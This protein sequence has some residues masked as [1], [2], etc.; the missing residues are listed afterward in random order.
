MKL[1]LGLSAE[2]KKNGEYHIAQRGD[3]LTK[4]PIHWT[5][6]FLTVWEVYFSLD[7]YTEHVL[8][9]IWH[10]GVDTYTNI[11]YQ[12][13]VTL[14]ISSRVCHTKFDLFYLQYHYPFAH[15]RDEWL[16]GAIDPYVC[17]DRNRW[18]KGIPFCSVLIDAP[19]HKNTILSDRKNT[20]FI[21]IP[22][23]VHLCSRHEIS[24]RYKP[25]RTTLHRLFTDMWEA[26]FSNVFL[27][28]CTLTPQC[29]WSIYDAYERNFEI[30][31]CRLD[32]ATSHTDIHTPK[33]MSLSMSLHAPKTGFIK[34]SF[35]SEANKSPRFA[36]DADDDE[37]SGAVLYGVYPFQW[38]HFNATPQSM[39][40][41]LDNHWSA[42]VA[43]WWRD[44]QTVGI[45]C[46]NL[47]FAR[48]KLQLVLLEHPVECTDRR[49]FNYYRYDLKTDL[50]RQVPSTVPNL[51]LIRCG[52]TW[53]DHSIRMKMHCVYGV[54]TA[55]KPTN[56]ASAAVHQ[57]VAS[58]SVHRD[59]HARSPI[60]Y[61]ISRACSHIF[62]RFR[63]LDRVTLSADR[64]L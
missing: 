54:M 31:C 62:Y 5:F 28:L 41:H 39:I 32:Y 20:L 38:H 43:C 11:P 13:C 24:S 27:R 23:H 42:E 9:Y 35:A 48:F 25:N 18:K 21:K 6:D 58:N 30:V 44:N 50:Q 61:S 56:L 63:H 64:H 59:D 3:K 37:H 19:P 26:W 33:R 17:V 60:N 52:R 36:V 45:L 46:K 51:R 34:I 12:F 55:K 7:P 2:H 40:W 4:Q 10:L 14:F 29:R 53:Y 16:D 47:Q 57:H 8:S 22:A 49:Y 1:H 15:R